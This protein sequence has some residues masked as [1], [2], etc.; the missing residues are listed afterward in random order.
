MAGFNVDLFRSNVGKNGFVQSNKYEVIIQP[1]QNFDYI[2]TNGDTQASTN[3]IVKD[4]RYRCIDAALPGVALRTMDTNRYGPGV[5]EKMPFTANYTDTSLTFICD[6][7][8]STYNFW[9][10]W[11]NYIFVGN[12]KDSQNS[13]IQNTIN[14]NRPY[15]TTAYKDDYAA[16]INIIVYENSGKPSLN[17]TLY[18]AYPL[19]INDSPLSWANNNNLLKLTVNMTF[20]EWA[21]NNASI[22]K[23]M[24]ANP[25]ENILF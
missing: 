15:Y 17:Y 10:G 20:R 13:A 16:S 2:F 24:L 25:N 5:L 6:K 12:G 7:N 23:K 8:G 11:L 22:E 4:L 14:S 3:D 19:S 18:K 1:N 21:Q 9:Y